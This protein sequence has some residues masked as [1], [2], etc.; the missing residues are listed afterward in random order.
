MAFMRR[1]VFFI[2]TQSLLMS[3]FTSSISTKML[4]LRLFILCVVAL[5]FG[6]PSFSGY[7]LFLLNASLLCLSPSSQHYDHLT[8]EKKT[9]YFAFRLLFIY[10]RNMPAC[11]LVLSVV[12]VGYDLCCISGTFSVC[13]L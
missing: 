5:K 10:F 3:V 12:L 8:G 9:E 4:T 2:L 6:C 11:L 1:S 13:I 7:I